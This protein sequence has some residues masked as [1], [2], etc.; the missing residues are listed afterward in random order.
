VVSGQFFVAGMA[1]SGPTGSAVRVRSFDEFADTFG[2]R[3]GYS[4]LSDTIQTFF[5]EGG[6]Q[7]YVSRA[8]GPNPVASARSINDR[9]GTPIPTIR[10]AAKTAGIAGDAYTVVVEAG[11]GSN[12]RMRIVKDSVTLETVEELTIAALIDAFTLSQHVVATNLASATVAPN[13]LPAVGTYTLTGGT[14][15]SAN[16]GASNYTTALDAFV[17]EL[18]DGAV[19]VPGVGSSV[20]ATLTTHAAANNRVALLSIGVS[21]DVATYVTVASNLNSSYT[22]L[23]GP[24]VVIPVPGGTTRTIP[25]EGYVAA[26]RNRAHSAFG[27]WRVPAG[28]FASTHYVTGVAKTWGRA[29]GDT[30]DA[31]K[32]N[33]IRS[34]NGSIR[35]YGY[36]STSTDTEFPLLSI[37]DLLNYLSTACDR[38]LEQ[39]VFQPID[40]KGQLLS[41]VTGALVGILE[42]I[43]TKGGVFP[44]YDE[45]GNRIDPGYS[46]S[47]GSSINTLTTLSNNEVHARI[48]IRPSP[49]AATL[50]VD[51]VKVGLL[52]SLV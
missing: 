35:L 10:I 36:R 7:A 37:R 44:L 42:P 16:A 25:P 5:A 23:F 46:V 30:L 17:P 4:Q 26:V 15:D 12:V 13:N 45:A 32:V 50:F 34:I 6:A 38:E 9:A 47:T 52:S 33:A 27:A 24:W 39:F 21:D 11:T 14:D 41:S 29:N 22:G 49:S 18:G 31:A 40:A 1:A 3:V 51:I 28:S 8:T 20:H 2:A 19:A 48:G 43:A